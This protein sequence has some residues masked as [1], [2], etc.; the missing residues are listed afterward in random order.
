MKET[1]MKYTIAL[2]ATLAVTS[3]SMAAH[4]TCIADQNTNGPA[5][6]LITTDCWEE[7]EKLITIVK[8]NRHEDGPIFFTQRALGNSGVFTHSLHKKHLHSKKRGL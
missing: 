2:I 3:Y 8:D 7:E 6:V 5:P 4:M 1:V